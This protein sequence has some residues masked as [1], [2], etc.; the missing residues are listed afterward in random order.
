MGVAY[1]Y[2]NNVKLAEEQFRLTLKYDPHFPKINESLGELLIK[3]RAYAEAIAYLKKGIAADP[4]SAVNHHLLGV[5]YNHVYDWKNAYNE[6]VLAIEMDPNEPANWQLC[7]EML[8]H[9]KRFDEAEQ[10]VRKALELHPE[11]VDVLV[12]LAELYSKRGE[13]A[14]AKKYI[15]QAL[16]IDPKNNRALELSWKLG[17]ARRQQAK[18]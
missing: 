5:A 9:L 7:G 13:V 18:Q 10:Y 4:Y 1:F 12:S 17:N 16:K 11:S 8:I 15:E 3:R 6:F 14:G 2:K